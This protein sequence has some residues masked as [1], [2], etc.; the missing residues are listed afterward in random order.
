DGKWVASG[1]QDTT[2]TLWDV[3]HCRGAAA[4]RN[5]KELQQLWTDLGSEDATVAHR[6]MGAFLADPRQAVEL[7]SQRLRPNSGLDAE[8]LGKVVSDLDNERFP[9]RERAHNELAK[10]GEL[11]E[12]FL[13]Q[14][15]QAPPSLEV[16]RRVQILLTR[17][18][19]STLAPDQL[20]ALRGFE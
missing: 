12:P 10:L 11:A 9:V 4:P 16:K 3:T 14:S 6:A 8:R 7:L 2:V 1:S 15:L 19:T 20:R 17:L 18:E 5:D 13:R